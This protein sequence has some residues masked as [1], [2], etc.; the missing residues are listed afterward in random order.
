MS[1]GPARVDESREEW[2]SD[3]YHAHAGAVRAYCQRFLR[4]ADDAAD[5]THEVF[6]RAMGGLQAPP[7]SGQARRW[8][9]TVAQNHCLDLVRRRR[10]MQSALTVLAADGEPRQQRSEADIMNRHLLEA[11][12]QQL[13]PRERKAL[14]QSAVEH[15]S[16]G[17]VAASLGISYSA[18][19]QVVHRARKHA[20]AIATRLAAVLGLAGANALRRRPQGIGL[21]Q[22]LAALAVVPLV[23]AVATPSSSG[24]AAGLS[25]PAPAHGS[26]SHPPSAPSIAG[27]LSMTSPSSTDPNQGG[28]RSIRRSV[29]TTVHSLLGTVTETIQELTS[30]TPPPA[31]ALSVPTMPTVP[32]SPALPTPP[33]APSIAP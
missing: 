12:L 30:V 18:A 19:A 27:G 32:A 17:E 22:T 23:I 4:S 29:G 20:S 15:R 1:V 10:R 7:R 5:A 9:I 31:P 16:I 3:L 14:W 25:P 26:A 33:P 2:L 6:V 28:L 8:L 21:V 24:H 11:V 13:G